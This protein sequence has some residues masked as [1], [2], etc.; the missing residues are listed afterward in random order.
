MIR[1]LRFLLRWGGYAAP[2]PPD[3]EAI[4][5]GGTFDTALRLEARFTDRVQLAGTFTPVVKI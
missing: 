5:L 4:V 1:L 3:V 2:S